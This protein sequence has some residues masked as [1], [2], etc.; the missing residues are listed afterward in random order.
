MTEEEV[1]MIYMY[2][3]NKNPDGLYPTEVDLIEFAN[4]LESYLKFQRNAMRQ[5]IMD[6]ISWYDS[7]DLEPFPINALR[8]VMINA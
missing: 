4:K 3:H 7:G 5:A 1:K 6:C 2:C 8:E